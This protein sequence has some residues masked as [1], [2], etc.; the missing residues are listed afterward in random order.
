M[1]K[2]GTNDAD[3]TLRGSGSL[4]SVAAGT[5]VPLR[6]GTYSLTI[7]GNFIATLVVEYSF[8]AQVTWVPATTLD[9]V[10]AS[11]TSPLSV[12]GEQ[13]EANTFVRLRCTAFTSGTANWRI[14]Y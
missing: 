6:S 5:A 13:P 12:V 1:S 11:F 10:A 14:G 9:G 7:W 2:L 3:P 4:S 8:D